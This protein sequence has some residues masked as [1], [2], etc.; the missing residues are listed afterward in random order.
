M[1][2]TQSDHPRLL[3]IGHSDHEIEKFI[4]LLRSHG[5]TAVADVRSSPYSRFHGQFNREPLM[6]SLR[7]A[8][9]DYVFLGAE[10]GARRSERECY[11]DGQAKYERVARLPAFRAGLDRL[12]RGLETHTI[13]LM[14]AEKDPITCHRMVLVCR[15]LRSEP[16]EIAHILADGQIETTDDAETRLLE[17]TNLAG[18]SLFEERSA[19]VERAYGIQ[20]EKIAYTE[21][22]VGPVVQGGAA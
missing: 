9:V 19:L 22:E 12:R 7:G 21:S 13:A 11:V 16:I 15:H 2:S 4:E 5:V 17:A 18:G 14:C 3:T 8:G 20:G 10:L 6:Q 1:I